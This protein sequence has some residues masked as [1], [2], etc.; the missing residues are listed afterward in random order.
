MDP[1]NKFNP[2]QRMLYQI[3]MRSCCRRSSSRLMGTS[4]FP[5]RG[6]GAEARGH[7]IHVLIFISSCYLLI[8]RTSRRWNPD[9]AHQAMVT[10]MRTS[11]RGA[12]TSAGT[13][14]WRHRGGP[15]F[16]EPSMT[17]QPRTLVAAL[18]AAMLLA[19]GLITGAAA[20]AAPAPRPS[21]RRPSPRGIRIA[22]TRHSTARRAA[23]AKG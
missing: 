6:H 17:F 7:T 5:L 2:L 11:R 19:P 8:T 14:R 22:W 9:G 4:R 18:C 23:Q 12:P 21:R 3:L 20:Q 10:G 15:F 1:Y 16:K 13:L